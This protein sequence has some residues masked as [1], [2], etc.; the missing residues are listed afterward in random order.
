[1]SRG[2]CGPRTSSTTGRSFIATSSDQPALVVL[3]AR[4]GDRAA[5]LTGLRPE[6]VLVWAMAALQR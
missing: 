3:M 2:N 5:S 6:A 4:P 1:M